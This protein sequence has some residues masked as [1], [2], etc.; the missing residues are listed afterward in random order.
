MTRIS[1][2]LRGA[3]HSLS[4]AS[5]LLLLLSIQ[6]YGQGKSMNKQD[7]QYP[8][9]AYKA[10]RYRS[11]GP[12]QGGRSIAVSGVVGKPNT[13]YFGSTGGGLWKTT[14]GGKTWLNISDKYF[15]RGAVGAIAVAPSDPNVVYAGMGESA[16]RG[17][18]FTGDGVYK[19]TDGGKTWKNIGLGETHVISRIVVDP[20]DPDLVYVAA[21]GH[22]FAENKDRGLYRSKDGGKTWEKILYVDDKTGAI[23]IS[24]DPNNSRVL[25][26]SFWQSYRTPW[27]M[28]SGGKGSGLY[29]STDGGDHWTNISH[30]PGMPKGL[31]GKIGVSVSPVNS[32]RVYALIEN[33]NGG[34]FRSDDAG[35][36]WL[37]L[38]HK[39]QLTQRAWYYTYIFADPKD[40]NTVYATDL[41]FYKSVDGGKSFDR[42]RTPHGDNHDLWLN[43]DNPQIMIESNDGGA[44]VS[45][46]GGKTWTEQDQPTAQ[47]YH[48]NLDNQFP[49]HIYG[50]S[51]DNSS[52]DIASRTTGYGITTSDWHEV[53]GG[54][55]GYIVPTPGKPWITYGGSYIGIMTSYNDHTKQTHNISV[56][57]ENT[58]G[59]GAGEITYRFNWTFPIMIS[60]H[61]PDA[62]YTAA[63]YLF[64]ST[65]QGMS[66][67][68]ISP[69][70]TRNDKTKQLRSGGPITKDETGTE[71]YDTIFSVA[72][73]PLKEGLIWVGSDDGLIHLTRDDGQHWED[74]TPKDI[75]DWS[76][77][78]I[79]EPSHFDAG[80]AYVAAS[81][82]K[83]DDFHPYLYK[84]TDYGKHW[85]KIT[86]G[87]PDDLYTRVIRQDAKDPNLLFAGTQNGVWVSFNGGDHWQP[88][89][90]NLPPVQVRDM[91]IQDRENDLVLA[92]H[93]RGFWVMDNLKPLRQLSKKVVDSDAYLF[94]PEHAYLMD[95]YSFHRE[96]MTIGENPPNGAV[97][98]YNLKN[99]PDSATTVKLDFL[100]QAGDTIA[101]FSSKSTAKKMSE[102]DSGDD[103]DEAMPESNQPKIEADSGMNR[104]VWDLRYPEVKNP[105][106]RVL[107]SSGGTLDGPKV[108]PSVYR[109]VLTAGKNT[110][111]QR[112]EVKKD[113]RIEA[114]QADLQAEFD[115]LKK[116]HDKQNVTAEKVNH[117]L[118]AKKQLNQYLSELKDNP[119]YSELKKA[120][121][122]ILDSL[123]AVESKLYQPDI[124]QSEDDLNY[125]VRLWIKLASLNTYVSSAYA[126]PPQQSY[127][128]FD[129]LNTQVDAQFNRLEP[130]FNQ[131]IPAFNK[132]VQDLGIPAVY[133][134]KD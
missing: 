43:P 114:A 29:K 82:Y 24:L 75:P 121:Q 21:L 36:T 100:T 97:I 111:E 90:L 58:D 64:K 40:E 87:I 7:Y 91:A 37:R 54:E 73:S 26:A 99:K 108:V 110:M 52:I 35:K 80:T 69:D 96:G 98:F 60:K 23:D 51:Q 27:I 77:I 115:L 42:I 56:W 133:I 48:V 120:A 104:F 84:T 16:I 128:L 132:K 55:S 78:S 61:N 81:R 130:I 33:K 10:L 8:K 57:Q 117:I 3:I 4:V 127:A 41:G 65:N 11:I 30:N 107:G 119:H 6:V 89:Q 85:T 70:L 105:P 2:F 101:T 59:Y 79:I 112:L 124:H 68:K 63:Q 34:V 1:H 134:K 13:F 116:I 46:N 109:V 88:L 49:Y 15:K 102:E 50:A 47:I 67:T 74:V 31:M 126:R 125:P 131:Q 118:S 17:N 93:G 94:E 18:M 62:L 45:Y 76:L 38:Y 66:W 25:Y 32:N 5:S 106:N 44:N 92:T 129:T 113:P 103:D 123:N 71:N 83:L 53:A 19:S 14:D 86:N 9:S 20:K 95:G 39:T 72:E 22:V 12:W 28:S 122:P